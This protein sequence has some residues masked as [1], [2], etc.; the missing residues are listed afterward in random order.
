MVISLKT[1]LRLSLRSPSSWAHRKWISQKLVHLLLLELNQKYQSE[2]A[3]DSVASSTFMCEIQDVSADLSADIRDKIDSPY[4]KIYQWVWSEMRTCLSVAENFPKNY[5]AWTHRR[6][7]CQLLCGM[8]FRRPHS[9][10]RD[11][12]DVI[13]T[14]LLFQLLTDELSTIQAWM[15]SHVSDHSAIH[16]QGQIL[17]ML[18]AV[19]LH[20][21][22]GYYSYHH[23]AQSHNLLQSNEIKNNLGEANNDVAASWAWSLVN[24]SLEMAQS[25]PFLSHEVSWI[26]RRICGFACLKL[27]EGSIFGDERLEHFY[28]IAAT[29]IC[30]SQTYKNGTGINIKSNE[31]WAVNFD[32]NILPPAAL[33]RFVQTEVHDLVANYFTKNDISRDRTHALTYIVWIVQQM[34]GSRLWERLRRKMEEDDLACTV[35][36]KSERGKE[37]EHLLV[38]VGDLVKILARDDNIVGN[39]WRMIMNSGKISDA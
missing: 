5:H 8:W 11:K 14:K 23:D 22:Q 7:A 33:E 17:R 24:R 2:S 27:L 6:W 29:N 34:K 9:D 18:L 16:Y 26:H 38:L 4:F 28:N 31:E 25:T 12:N 13:E 36:S 37:Q 3:M 20:P 32:P 10:R 15:K 1:F 39:A 35:N 19:G 30:K 21:T